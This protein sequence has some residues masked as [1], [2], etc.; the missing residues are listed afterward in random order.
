[1][2]S[3]QRDINFAVA[4]RNYI[5]SYATI[6]LTNQGSFGIVRDVKRAKPKSLVLSPCQIV[7]WNLAQQRQARGWSQAEMAKRLEPYLGYRM[8]RAA[9][10]KAE[11]SLYDGPI[12]RFDAD[13]IFALARIFNKPVGDF[14]LPPDAYFRGRL[15]TINGI[16]GITKA[17]VSSKPLSRN[18][19]TDLIIRVVAPLPTSRAERR[20]EQLIVN[21]II[22]LAA[23]AATPLPRAFEAA[24]RGNLEDRPEALKEVLK[25]EIPPEVL[26]EEALREL[27]VNLLPQEEQELSR[28]IAQSV[29]KAP[30]PRKGSRK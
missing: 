27:E 12:R 29:E 22:D 20:F 3:I 21:R 24:V 23:Q 8:S 16:P 10:S 1:M 28:N 5:R 30:K 25:G 9:I 14:F 7:A 19:A 2:L 18:E 13:E 17:R 4:R 15:V 26:R 11:R 6:R